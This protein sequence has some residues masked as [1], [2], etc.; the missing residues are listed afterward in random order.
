MSKIGR[1]GE[2][3]GQYIPET[4]MTAVHELEKAYD[5]Y[6]DDPEFNKELQ[7]LYHNYAGRPSMLYYAEKMT[8]DLGG[9]K[10]YIKREDLN[11]TGSHKINNV[12][13]QILLAKKMGKKRII[14]ETG[15]GQHGVATATV[16]ALMG[17]ECEVYMGETDM[18][19]QSLNVYRM[20]LLGAKVTGVASGTATLKDAINEAFRDWVSNIDTTFYCIGSVMGPHAYPTMVRDFQKVISAEIKAQLME[21]EGRLPDCVVAC[22]GGGS[23]AMGAFYNF[24]EDKSVKLVGAEAA[25]RGVDTPDHAATVAKGSLGIFHGMKSLF[26]QN[27]YGQIDPVYSISAGLDYPG[28]GPEHAYLNSIGR[29]QYVD[30]TDEE[31]VCAFEY[32]SRTEGIIPAIESSHAVAAALKIAPTMDKDSILVINLSGR[33]DKDVYSIARYREVDLNEE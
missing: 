2:F 20:N 5:K 8:K 27:E 3:G 15:A 17:L 23:N 33:G 22:V 32:L 13:G 9:A 29:A 25:G 21:K 4:V 19:R 26:L 28:I 16:C 24:I 12:L 6:K 30:I 1:F 10:I 11:H 31:A 14:A 18:K 7:E